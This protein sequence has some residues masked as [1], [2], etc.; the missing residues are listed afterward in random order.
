MKK[1]NLKKLILG[2]LEEHHHLT[3]DN[4]RQILT[5]R[6]HKFHK[7][8]IYRSLDRLMAEDKICQQ[9]LDE[10][11]ASYELR[12]KHHEHLKCK[13]CGKVIALDCIFDQPKNIKGFNID[14]HHL[15]LIGTCPDCQKN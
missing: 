8:S 4:I 1:R 10:K 15:T 9:F 6:Q 7:T 5:Q 13:I 11:Q 2:I 3:T 14:H 12:S